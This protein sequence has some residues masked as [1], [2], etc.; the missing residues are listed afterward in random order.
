MIH[1]QRLS[2]TKETEEG[3]LGKCICIN[4]IEYIFVFCYQLLSMFSWLIVHSISCETLLECKGKQNI[5]LHLHVNLKVSW[6][7]LRAWVHFL[8]PTWE[9]FEGWC[10]SGSVSIAKVSVNSYVH[11]SNFVWKTLYSC[12]QPAPLI[13]II[14]SI[15]KLFSLILSPFYFIMFVNSSYFTVPILVSLLLQS[16]YQTKYLNLR[17]HMREDMK[18]LLYGYG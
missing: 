8:L 14:F 5:P 13:L 1:R 16:I 10:G 11:Q 9:F 2:E 15:L 12:S 17:T 3:G 7:G 4:T 6:S 18:H